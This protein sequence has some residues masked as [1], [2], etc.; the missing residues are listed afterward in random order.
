MLVVDGAA[1]VTNWRLYWWVVRGEGKWRKETLLEGNPGKWFKLETDLGNASRDRATTEDRG[2]EW[3]VGEGFLQGSLRDDANLSMQERKWKMHHPRTL[4]TGN[5]ELE[6]S[7]ANWSPFKIHH[8]TSSI[9]RMD[10]F[11]S[12]RP[13]I[14]SSISVHL[15]I[16][17]GIVLLIGTSC[18][19]SIT[20]EYEGGRNSIGNDVPF[21]SGAKNMVLVGGTVILMI[22]HRIVDQQ[23]IYL[24]N[25]SIPIA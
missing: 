23:K 18:E 25:S 12:S 13:Q 5:K 11:P 15:L 20:K 6:K 10:L 17:F 9:Q 16:L 3:A 8:T 1:I 21:L 24:S 2:L 22:N 19:G 7:K 4:L 14:G